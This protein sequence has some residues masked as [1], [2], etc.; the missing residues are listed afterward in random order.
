MTRTAMSLLAI[1][2]ALAPMAYAET[3]SFPAGDFT[4]IDTSGVVDV[5]FET[6][7]TA[8]VEVEQEDGDFSDIY[9]GQDGS[10]LEI[11]P[12]QGRPQGR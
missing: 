3:R 6:G 11:D 7:E 8:S 4:G 1:A 10:T 5:V 12:P 9:I 2:A